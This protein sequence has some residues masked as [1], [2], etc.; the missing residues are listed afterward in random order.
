MPKQ[1]KVMSCT[2]SEITQKLSNIDGKGN[3][4]NH[5]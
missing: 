3:L 5:N 2:K 4:I 1:Y